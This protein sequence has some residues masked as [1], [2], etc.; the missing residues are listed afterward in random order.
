MQS[1]LLF[2]NGVAI[3]N[4]ERFLEKCELRLASQ[5]HLSMHCIMQC[6]QCR[7]SAM[8]H[9]HMDMT[10]PSDLQMAGDSHRWAAEMAQVQATMP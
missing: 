4:N 10:F 1:V 2:V 7:N 9:R 3:L 8:S 5:M 6:K